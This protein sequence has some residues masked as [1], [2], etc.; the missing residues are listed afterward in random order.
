MK[1]EWGIS[2]NFSP[3]SKMHALDDNDNPICMSESRVHNTGFKIH[4]FNRYTGDDFPPFACKK[5]TRLF[6]LAAKM[7]C[8]EIRKEKLRLGECL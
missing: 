2:D 4:A 3:T 5:C 6:T 7:D 1:Y 8:I